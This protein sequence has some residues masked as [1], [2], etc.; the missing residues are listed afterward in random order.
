MAST[1]SNIKIQLMGTGENSGTWGNV[2]NVNLS[3]A[4][5]QAIVETATITFSSAN[6]TLTFDIIGGM[7]LAKPVEELQNA[8]SFNYYGNTEI[9]DERATATEDVS[10]LDAKFAAEFY[11]TPPTPKINSTLGSSL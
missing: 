9:Y 10:K 8:L 11:E 1:Y 3:E 6:V 5:E 4:I 2:T 7:G